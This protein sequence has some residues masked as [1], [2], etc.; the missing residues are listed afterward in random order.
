[1]LVGEDCFADSRARETSC[2]VHILPHRMRRS[3]Q[4]QLQENS[5]HREHH[6]LRMVSH[7]D[8]HQVNTGISLC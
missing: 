4:D 7:F 5:H 3:D 6:R 1:V 8:R 2:I